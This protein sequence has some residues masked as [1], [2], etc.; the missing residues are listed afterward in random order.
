MKFLP[1]KQLIVDIV[2]AI[3]IG[4]FTYTAVMKW[5]H[6]HRF[7]RSLQQ[8]PIMHETAPVLA[9]FIPAVE[10]GIAMLLFFPGTR[11]IGLLL[12]TVLMLVFTGYVLFILTTMGQLPCSCGGI[13]EQMTWKQ[14]LVFNA[15]LVAMGAAGWYQQNRTKS[16]LQ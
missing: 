12:A 3:F 10:L 6:L 13:I 4:L 8:V 11:T 16:L 7:I 15:A 14:H 2:A 1:P 9:G 5:R